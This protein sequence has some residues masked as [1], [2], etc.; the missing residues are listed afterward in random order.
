MFFLALGQLR[1]YS[2]RRAWL[3]RFAAC[4]RVRSLNSEEEKETR[5]QNH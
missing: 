4:R 2:A 1:P 3:V 5:W